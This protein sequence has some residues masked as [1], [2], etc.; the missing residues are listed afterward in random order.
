MLVFR[1]KP[2]PLNHHKS[3]PVRGQIWNNRT[4]SFANIII[5]CNSSIFNLVL[6]KG[7][8]RVVPKGTG[9]PSWGNNVWRG[10]RDEKLFA[11]AKIFFADEQPPQKIPRYAPGFKIDYFY[12]TSENRLDL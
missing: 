8:A 7:V 10:Y 12:Y 3:K 6:T 9:H 5:H 11:G 4:S 1:N 2:K